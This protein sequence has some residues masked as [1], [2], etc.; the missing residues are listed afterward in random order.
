[1]QKFRI[2]INRI[3]DPIYFRKGGKKK[4]RNESDMKLYLGELS[5]DGD[6]KSI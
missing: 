3:L 1:M 6:L 4:F 2:M 5:H